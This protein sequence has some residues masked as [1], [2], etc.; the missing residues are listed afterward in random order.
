MK[1]KVREI[2][3]KTEEG[4][5]KIEKIEEYEKKAKDHN[6]AAFLDGILSSLVV[7]EIAL[8]FHGIITNDDFNF[9]ISLLGLVMSIGFGAYVFKLLASDVFDAKID[10]MKAS[11]LENEILATEEEIKV[12]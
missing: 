8:F 9:I 12:K 3:N 7:L 11:A 2:G 1:D 5:L 10:S 4:R 6:E